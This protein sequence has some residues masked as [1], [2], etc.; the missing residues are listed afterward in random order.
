MLKGIKEELTECRVFMFTH[1]IDKR[2]Q[3]HRENKFAVQHCLESD[4]VRVT[5]IIQTTR[6]VNYKSVKN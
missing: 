5:I 3:V 6:F 2:R 1:Y 4:K